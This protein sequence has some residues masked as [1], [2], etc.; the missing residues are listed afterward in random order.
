MGADGG[1]RRCGGLNETPMSAAPIPYKLPA[2]P[3]PVYYAGGE[4]IDRF[5]RTVSTPPRPED[6]IGATTALPEMILPPGRPARLRRVAASGR[7][8]PA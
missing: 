5:R 4:N 7:P 8:E 2:N 3:V 6:W 1:R